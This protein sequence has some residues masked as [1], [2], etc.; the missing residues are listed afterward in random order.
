M[1]GPPAYRLAFH[2]EFP[3]DL[4]GIPSN[5]AGRIL[6]AVE[7]RLGKAPE[8]YGERLRQSLHGFWKM[9]VGDYRVIYEIAGSEVRIYG[10]LDRRDVY[11]EIGKRTSKGWSR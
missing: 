10:V 11:G 9:R 6:K 3:D 7:G 5:I 1:A 8:Q 4:R 2:A